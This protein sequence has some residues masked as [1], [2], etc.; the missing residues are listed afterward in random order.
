MFS[1]F[2]ANLTFPPF[3]GAALASLL[4]TDTCLRYCWGSS[5]RPGRIHSSLFVISKQASPN[6]SC[7]ACVAR[8]TAGFRRL[9]SVAARP[10]LTAARSGAERSAFPLCWW[11]RIWSAVTQNSSDEVSTWPIWAFL[12]TVQTICR[13]FFFQHFFLFQHVGLMRQY[14]SFQSYIS[15]CGNR[16]RSQDSFRF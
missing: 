13:F 2:Y 11:T 9:A 16:S 4:T 6:K 1:L 14:M 8:A 15:R 10:Y 7:A 12:K 5:R 3:S